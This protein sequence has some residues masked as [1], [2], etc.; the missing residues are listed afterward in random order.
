MTED[1]IRREEHRQ[2]RREVARRA[3]GMWS[4]LMILSC[5]LITAVVTVLWAAYIDRQSNHRWCALVSTLDD[6]YTQN[7]PATETGRRVAQQIHVL[8]SDFGCGV[9][10]ER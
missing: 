5:S 1:E 3:I 2:F 6:A 9:G 8:R 10:P 4:V 7:P